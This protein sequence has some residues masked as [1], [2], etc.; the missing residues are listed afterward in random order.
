M[1][2]QEYKV[3]IAGITHG[4]RNDVLPDWQKHPQTKLVALADPNTSVATAVQVEYGIP[5]RYYD[6]Q[7]MLANESPDIVQVLTSN[8]GKVEVIEEASKQGEI[9][10]SEKPLAA[11]LEDAKK[12]KAVV[13]KEKAL[14]LINWYTAWD[15]AYRTMLKLAKGGDIGDIYRIYDR[16]GHAGP[17][18]MGCQPEFVAWL[19]DKEQNGGGA[20]MDF[21]SYGAVLA[22]TLLGRPESVSGTTGNF[23][24]PYDVQDDNAVFTA[25]YP[26]AIATME[27]TWSWEGSPK[28][29][30]YTA[31]YGTKGSLTL[32]EDGK[33]INKMVIKPQCF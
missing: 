12:I 14:L 2:S 30:G 33:L 8:K 23:T 26:N 16:R 13:E 32:T 27:G 20:G 25:R 4:H 22:A 6:W 18:E 28:T 17:L 19:Y 5:Q 31:I 1:A 3:A 21:G 9:I 24:K 7:E 10:V 11:N 29:L 15:P